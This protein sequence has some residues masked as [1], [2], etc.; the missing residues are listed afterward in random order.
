MKREKGVK[1]CMKLLF[2]ALMLVMALTTGVKAQAATWVEINQK[3]FPDSGA[4]EALINK[5]SYEDNFKQ[6]KG[7]YY[8]NVTGVTNLY[9]YGENN[10]KSYDFLKKFTRL[11]SISLYD[12]KT[13]R[14]DFTKNTRLTEISISY[15]PRLVSIKCPKSVQSLSLYE[16]NIS[17]LDVRELQGLKS[18]S[19]RGNKKMC[20][21]DVSNN[22]KL[23]VLD[24]SDSSIRSIDV[25]KCK[26][27]T[28][29][30]CYNAK[31]ADLKIGKN[32]KLKSIN[33]HDNKKLTNLDTSLCPNLKDV[34]A[35]NTG[36]TEFDATK[37][38]KLESLVLSGTAIKTLDV[39]KCPKLIKLDVS[40]TAIKTLN[41][42]KCYKL[43]YLVVNDTAIKALNVTKNRNLETIWVSGA[44]KLKSL[45]V[46]QC[47]KLRSVDISGSGITKINLTRNK[48]LSYFCPGNT[49]KK[50]T[51]VKGRKSIELGY[52]GLKKG[53]VVSLKNIIGS[54]YTL[55]QKNKNIRFNPKT[56]KF[57]ILKKASYSEWIYLKKGNS[58]CTIYIDYLN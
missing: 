3:N 21:V 42:T 35:W 47:P 48:K 19:V 58:S 33:V 27:L 56:M 54:G 15:A 16:T 40:S 36:T 9:F 53:S 49:C 37:N 13:T 50:I 8:V 4:R 2:T 23:E 43:R 52:S 32:T 12:V 18:L 20:A 46:T 17:R 31:L 25:R 7:K 55:S 26:R 30:D 5:A 34:T 6:S 38:R 57:Q 28:S 22:K 41:V 45:N 51:G 11:E 24:A 44:K 14:V 1:Q 29:L 39:T 10:I